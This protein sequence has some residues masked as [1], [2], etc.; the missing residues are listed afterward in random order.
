MQYCII[1]VLGGG[2]RRWRG[3]NGGSCGAGAGGGGAGGDASRGEFSQLQSSA[4]RKIYIL[5][6]AM[7]EM[8]ALLD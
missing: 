2:G 4:K 8:G 5:L 7:E 1:E 3:F 6:L